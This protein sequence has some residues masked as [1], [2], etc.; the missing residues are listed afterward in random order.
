[1]SAAEEEKNASGTKFCIFGCRWKCNKWWGESVESECIHLTQDMD[2]WREGLC[3]HGK[4]PLIFTE[5]GGF[6]DYLGDKWLQQQSFC[7]MELFKIRPADSRQD[8]DVFTDCKTLLR[9]AVRQQNAA[10]HTRTCA[11]LPLRPS[12]NHIL[13]ANVISILL[14]HNYTQIQGHRVLWLLSRSPWDSSPQHPN[15]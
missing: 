8:G 5:A 3:E 10:S 2:R 12:N 6:L 9:A 11:A 1:M 4:K 7:S 14:T 15:K 13:L